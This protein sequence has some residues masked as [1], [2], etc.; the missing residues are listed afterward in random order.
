M[1]EDAAF[2]LPEIKIGTIPGAGGTQRLARAL[3][4]YKAMEL[5]LTGDTISGKELE[6]LGLIK[7]FQRDQVLDQAMSLAARIGKMSGAVTKLA[8][9]AVLTGKRSAL[10]RLLVFCCPWCEADRKAQPKT[11]ISSPA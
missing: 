10:L 6:Q 3:G 7:A 1:A 2:G 9:Q 4:K 11:P 5:I 8:K